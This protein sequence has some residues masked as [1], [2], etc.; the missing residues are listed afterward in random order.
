ME[1]FSDVITK[2]LEV[3]VTEVEVRPYDAVAHHDV[4]NFVEDQC[5]PVG[6]VGIPQ[7]LEV[8]L[9]FE[10]FTEGCEGGLVDIIRD[11]ELNFFKFLD[12]QVFD[13]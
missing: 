5:L 7:S 10:Q 1:L 11:L 6:R 3:W 12:D 13:V 2:V 8:F 9:L 4:D